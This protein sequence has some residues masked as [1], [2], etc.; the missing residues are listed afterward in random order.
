M[1]DAVRRRRRDE[2][3]FVGYLPMPP[4]RVVF[5]RFVIPALLMLAVFVAAALARLHGDPGDGTWDSGVVRSFEG[6]VI[7]RPYPMLHASG[8]AESAPTET[9]LL[10]EVGKFGGGQRAAAFDGRRVV[11]SGWPLERGGRRMIELEPGA[12]AIRAVNG[13][14]STAASADGAARPVETRLGHVTL[15]GEIVDSKCYLGAMK[16]GDGK[17]HKE[18][19]TLCIA[20]GIPPMFVTR[21]AGGRTTYYLLTSPDGG[22]LSAAAHPFIADPVEVT[23]ELVRVADLLELRVAAEQ[24]RRR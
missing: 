15:R 3:F 20:G 14:A 22:P 4:T 17:T 11:V 19:A 16:P 24:I 5:L 23:G 2:E 7:A 9:L 1:A 21:D 8:V 13:P 10:V 18:C 6:V 12:A